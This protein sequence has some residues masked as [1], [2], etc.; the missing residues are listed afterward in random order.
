MRY[1]L[2]L[3]ICFAFTGCFFR[4]S[5]SDKLYTEGKKNGSY[6]VINRLWCS[7]C[8]CEAIQAKRFENKKLVEDIVLNCTEGCPPGD[9]SYKIVY[10]YIGAA[11]FETKYYIFVKDLNLKYSSPLTAADSV[12]IDKLKQFRGKPF[13]DQ[14]CKSILYSFKGYVETSSSAIIRFPA[15]Y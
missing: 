5:G 13:F 8:G 10:Q 9:R 11:L 2:L 6:L 3:L 15:K 12:L 14:Y 1:L 4:F 7:Q